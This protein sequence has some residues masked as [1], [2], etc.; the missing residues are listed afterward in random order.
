M[1][2]IS[3]RPSTRPLIGLHKTLQLIS[4]LST[5][6]LHFLLLLGLTNSEVKIERSALMKMLLKDPLL[7]IGSELPLA[8]IVAFI[9]TMLRGGCDASINFILAVIFRV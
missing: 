2:L 3:V 6:Q 7:S 1:S 4:T 5:S 9:V 8:A